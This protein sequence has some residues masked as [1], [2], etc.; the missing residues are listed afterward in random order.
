VRTARR[1]SDGGTPGSTSGAVV[2]TADLAGWAS[3]LRGLAADVDDAE[4]I[5]Q[6]RLLEELKS[7]AAAAQAVVTAAFARSQRAASGVPVSAASAAEREQRRRQ[8]AQATRS[9]RGQVALARK[10]APHCGGRHVGLAEV[11]ID[12]CP[13]PWLRW[14]TELFRN[15]GRR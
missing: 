4:R 9:I 2:S 14:R 3:A 1:A 10:E 7:A 5:E 8:A 13:V 6:L 15:G 12:E 11:L